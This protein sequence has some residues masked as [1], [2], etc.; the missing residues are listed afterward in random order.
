MTQEAMTSRGLWLLQAACLG[1]R[2]LGFLRSEAPWPGSAPR[3]ARAQPEGPRRA[4]GAWRCGAGAASPGG[5]RRPSR[6]RRQ[7]TTLSCPGPPRCPGF[8]AAHPRRP[9]DACGSSEAAYRTG[10]ARRGPGECVQLRPR[11]RGHSALSSKAV[12][13]APGGGC[14]LFA[15]ASL[16]L[17]P[18]EVE[19]KIILPSRVAVEK[20]DM[21]YSMQ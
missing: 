16:F 9:T 14:G 1:G 2:R 18:F 19:I 17:L 10:A 12:C 3:A 15:A 6:R 5:A 13:R 20:S 7:R 8:S 21:T 11:V 4:G